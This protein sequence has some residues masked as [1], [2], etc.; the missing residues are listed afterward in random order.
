MQVKRE[1][2][3]WLGVGGEGVRCFFKKIFYPSKSVIKVVW[4][5]REMGEKGKEGEKER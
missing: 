5:E 4:R 3:E 2:G 1:M